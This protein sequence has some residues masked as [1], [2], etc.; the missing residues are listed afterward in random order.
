MHTKKNGPFF[1]G[2]LTAGNL[3]SVLDAE[4]A[5]RTSPASLL[6]IYLNRD[7]IQTH[8]CKQIAVALWATLLLVHTECGVA[9]TRACVSVWR[10]ADVPLLHSTVSLERSGKWRKWRNEVSSRR[11]PYMSYLRTLAEQSNRCPWNWP[12]AS[13]P[14]DTRSGHVRDRIELIASLSVW[15]LLQNL[16]NSYRSNQIRSEVVYWFIKVT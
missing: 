12:M 8:F 6:L 7:S 4:S 5:V 1:L 3:Q 16:I 15:T 11:V 14:E 10:G 13:R 2:R 9:H